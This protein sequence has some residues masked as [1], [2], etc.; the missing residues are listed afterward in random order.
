MQTTAE[1]RDARMAWT[2]AIHAGDGTGTWNGDGRRCLALGTETTGPDPAGDELLQLAAVDMTGRMVLDLRFRPAH[3]DEWPEAMAENHITPR[4][5]ADFDPAQAH[6]RSITRIL[7]AFP[8]VIGFDVRR[9][10]RFLAAAGI[11]FGAHAVEVGDEYATVL[12]HTPGGLVAVAADL[13]YSGYAGHA[14]DALDDARAAL[15]CHRRL[16]AVSA[17]RR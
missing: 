3:H 10:L 13:G 1:T 2:G 8:T 7:R 16:L 4:S 5:V 14:H 17:G 11:G 15:Y 12:G 9:S 6:A